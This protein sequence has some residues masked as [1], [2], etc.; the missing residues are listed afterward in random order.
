MYRLLHMELASSE[1]HHKLHNINPSFNNY[2]IWKKY[3]YNSQSEQTQIN[4]YLVAEFRKLE[5]RLTSVA[6]S[7][8]LRVS[9]V[10]NW[11]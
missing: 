10:L 8:T 2:S 6:G 4:L 9:S 5:F 1:N 7:R 3:I 11:V